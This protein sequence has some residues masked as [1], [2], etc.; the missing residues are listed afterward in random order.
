MAGLR[1]TFTIEGDTQLDRTLARFADNLGDASQLWDALADRFASVEARQ[2]ASEGAY[3]SG[4]WPALSPAYAAWKARHYPGKPILERTGDL[5]DSL[6]SR[7]FGI[8][9]ITPRSMTLGSGVSYHKFHQQGAGALPQRRPVE[10]PE[11]ERRHWARLM[12]RFVVTGK[13]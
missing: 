6:T 2:F 13:V 3:A 4:G 5:K 12:Q 11:S 10:L 8:E 7:P 1:L 9:V